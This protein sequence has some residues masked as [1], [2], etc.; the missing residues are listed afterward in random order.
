VIGDWRILHDEK[1]HKF[2][3]LADIREIKFR[4]TYAKMGG[5]Y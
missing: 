3:C 4:K 2:C 5:E 1:L